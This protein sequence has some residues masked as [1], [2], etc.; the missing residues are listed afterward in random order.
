MKQTLGFDFIIA[1]I[2]LLMQIMFFRHL[3]I[4]GLQADIVFLFVLWLCARRNR[5]YALGF[6]AI[7]ALLLDILTDT[8]GV[9]LFS[10]TLLVLGAHR[11]V[12]Q[13][14]ENKLL[15]GQTFMLIFSIAIAYNLIFL[16]VSSFAG[17]YDT[18][19]M[20]IKY[21]IG[22]SVYTALVGIIFYLLTSE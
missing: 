6:T 22:N 1:V 10:K 7:V 5:T 3:D 16:L 2:F 8:W 21:W 12:S 13:Q 9:H 19:L 17:I 11:L 14:A 15:P 18:N 4:W 20:F